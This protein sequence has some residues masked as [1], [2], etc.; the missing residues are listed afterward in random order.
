MRPT[1]A[2]LHELKAQVLLD[3][4]QAWAAVQSAL[5][6]TS[7]D[8]TWADGYLTLSRAQF[9]FGEPEE[10]LISINEALRL[11]PDHADA[12]KE[13]IDIKAQVQRRLGQ[14]VPQ[15]APTAEPRGQEV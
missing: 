3:A 1:K 4:G 2:V 8:S 13:I 14:P 12:L 11:Q 15:R 7:L 5:K 6:A 10:A 9:N